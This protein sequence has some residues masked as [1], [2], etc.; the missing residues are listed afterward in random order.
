[1]EAVQRKDPKTFFNDRL[2]VKRWRMVKVTLCSPNR[3]IFI[4]EFLIVSHGKQL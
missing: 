3:R 4:F 1:M 2:L